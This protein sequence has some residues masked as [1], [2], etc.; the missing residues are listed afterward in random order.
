VYVRRP[1]PVDV[2]SSRQIGTDAGLL[3]AP[4]TS[5]Y[6]IL[7]PAE[8]FDV[9]IDSMTAPANT[10][11]GPT[12]NDARDCSSSR[13]LC[14]YR[15]DG[16]ISPSGMDEMVTL[17]TLDSDGIALIHFCPMNNQPRMR[18]VPTGDNIKGFTLMVRVGPSSVRKA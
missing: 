11:D 4:L 15:G 1:Q 6:S 14:A 13:T 3:P 18:F 17:C 5:H 2:L 7:S 9:V 8:R 16:P 12:T 10:S